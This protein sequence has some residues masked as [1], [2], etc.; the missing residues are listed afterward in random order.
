VPR[1][2]AQAAA[3]VVGSTRRIGS[4]RTGTAKIIY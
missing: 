2:L 1:R 3:E 4:V